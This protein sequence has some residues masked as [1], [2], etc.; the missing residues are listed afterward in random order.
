MKTLIQKDACTPVFIVAIFTL[1]EIWKQPKCPLIDEWLKKNVVYTYN[2]IVSQH[3]KEGN[4]T[5]KFQYQLLLKI[6]Y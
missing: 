4:L 2:V 6:L 3:K 5:H 1:A